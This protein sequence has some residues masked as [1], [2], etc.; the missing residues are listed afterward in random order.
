MKSGPIIERIPNMKYFLLSVLLLGFLCSCA[1]KPEPQ[2][3]Y[4]SRFYTEKDALMPNGWRLHED[5]FFAKPESFDV[6][7]YLGLDESHEQYDER[8][9]LFTVRTGSRPTM[10]YYC[11]YYPVEDDSI[12]DVV[13]DAAGKGSFNLGVEFFDADQ[14][15]LGERHQGFN[16]LPVT[17]DKPF[18]TYRFRL[19]FLANE[20]KKARYVRLMFTIDSSSEL[21]LRNISLNVTPYEIDRMDSS[22]VK[23]KEKEAQQKK[24]SSSKRRN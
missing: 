8:A 22:Y 6:S 7:P 21:T 18:K 13:A 20:N 5:G 3:L 12:I 9:N 2:P 16:I 14:E 19:Y 1:H 17:G 10:Y 15:L 11:G 23:F 24:S 4:V